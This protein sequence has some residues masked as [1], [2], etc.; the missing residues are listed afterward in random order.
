MTIKAYRRIV[1]DTSC[2]F[3]TR[4]QGFHQRRIA[5]EDAERCHTD[6]HGVC[7]GLHEAEMLEVLSATPATSPK[8]RDS[9]SISIRVHRTALRHLIVSTSNAESVELVEDASELSARAS[10]NKRKLTVTSST[11]SQRR[12]RCDP[13]LWTCAMPSPTR[14]RMT[15]SQRP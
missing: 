10:S 13:A 5:H 6:Q 4:D 15:R 9:R 2:A 14:T 7:G 11:S 8:R 12:R 1:S 3:D